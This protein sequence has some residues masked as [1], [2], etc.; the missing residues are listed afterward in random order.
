[1]RRCPKC[2]VDKPLTEFYLKDKATN[3]VGG[4]CKPC[5]MNDV[6]AYRAAHLEYYREIDRKRSMLP[7]RVNAREQWASNHPERF[8]A[9]RLVENAVKAGRIVKLPCMVC[10][11]VAEAHHPDYSAPLDVVWLCRF[12]H[13]Q[14]HAMAKKAA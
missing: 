14:A 8:N 7:H 12:H 9:K 4:K 10:G 1:M 3:R 2:G 11:G 13:K 6:R 5:H